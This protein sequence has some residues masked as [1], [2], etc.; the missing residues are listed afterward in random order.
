MA[1]VTVRAKRRGQLPD[2]SWVDEGAEFQIEE[3]KVSKR[4]MVVLTPKRAVK[5]KATADTGD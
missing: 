3:A 2:G 1:D 4:W 5:A